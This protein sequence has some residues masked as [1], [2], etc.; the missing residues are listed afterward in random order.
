MLFSKTDSEMTDGP[1]SYNMMPVAAIDGF[2]SAF[3]FALGSQRRCRPLYQ[4]LA[5]VRRVLGNVV[6]HYFIGNLLL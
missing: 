6:M 5:A 1:W 4:H 2:V 3:T